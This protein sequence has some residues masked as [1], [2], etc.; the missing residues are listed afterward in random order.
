MTTLKRINRK[1]IVTVNGEQF[2]FETFREA[3]TFIFNRNG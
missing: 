3:L 1:H 2:V